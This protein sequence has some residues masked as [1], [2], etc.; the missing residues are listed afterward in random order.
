MGKFLVQS[1]TQLSSPFQDVKPFPKLHKWQ[2]H[3]PIKQIISYFTLSESLHCWMTNVTEV[4]G[5]QDQFNSHQ[6]HYGNPCRNVHKHLTLAKEMALQTV[7]WIH[8]TT[9]ILSTFHS[10]SNESWHCSTVQL[11]GYHKKNITTSGLEIWQ[12]CD[13]QALSFYCPLWLHLWAVQRPLL[14]T[15]RPP[16]AQEKQG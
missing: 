15:S 5:L 10:H 6:N 14:G 3:G 16:E 11:L 13:L 1:Q 9:V 12:L 4:D 7:E 8:S 2:L